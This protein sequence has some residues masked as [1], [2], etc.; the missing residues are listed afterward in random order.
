ML[1]VA[2]NEFNI[3]CVLVTYFPSQEV[4]SRVWYIAQQF[5]QV[6]IVDNTPSASF[7]ESLENLPAN[8]CWL[9]N[10]DNLGIAS[11]LNRG[12][13]FLIKNDCDWIFLFDQDSEPQ[14]D[15][16]KHLLNVACQLKS[17]GIPVAQVGPAYYEKQRR[18]I[19]PFIRIKNNR[20]ERSTPDSN[21]LFQRVSYLI[22]SGCC[23]SV[24]CWQSIGGFDEGLFID[25]VDIEW[26]LRA[27]S[28]GF[29]SFGVA[30]AIMKHVL[31]DE[32]IKFLGQ[33]YPNHSPLRHYYLFRNSI[34]LLKR[35]YIPPAW[36]RVEGRK[37]CLRFVA[38][39]LLTS[40]RFSHIR[41]MCKGII[42]GI[43]GK[44]GRID[45]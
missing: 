44:M 10:G 30:S 31:G 29:Q 6:V 39:A 28:Q 22:T 16:I 45:Y 25:F 15:M 36:K 14:L 34:L 11:A 5:P 2:S 19:A 37:L 21:A 1:S 13:K 43:R 32:P 27:D 24:K 20:L 41:M 4:L 3:G 26:G 7:N 8:V 17:Q 9:S 40:S 33:R 23:I 18:Y 42:D 38:Y 12:I 35:A